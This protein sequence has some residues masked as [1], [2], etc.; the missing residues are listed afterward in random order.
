MADGSENRY[1]F[2]VVSAISHPLSAIP[3]AKQLPGFPRLPDTSRTCALYTGAYE[4]E[5]SVTGKGSADLRR[6]DGGSEPWPQSIN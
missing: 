4:R 1:P 3:K 6:R 5:G 2:I